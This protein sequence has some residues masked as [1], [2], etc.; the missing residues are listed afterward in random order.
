MSLTEH[1]QQPASRS[2]IGF[3]QKIRF[4]LRE[5]AI[6]GKLAC[7]M[8]EEFT[9]GFYRTFADRKQNKGIFYHYRKSS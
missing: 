5:H 6:D 2:E 7:H 3:F 4:I 1:Y 8:F 9:K